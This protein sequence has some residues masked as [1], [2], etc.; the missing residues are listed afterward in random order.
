MTN[1]IIEAFQ[2]LGHLS[3]TSGAVL[4]LFFGLA[5]LIVFP[6]TI[7][8]VAAGASFGIGAAPIILVAGT[9]GGTLAFLL[10]RYIASG[11][12]RRKLEQRSKLEA[13]AEAVDKE[14][15][16]IVALMRL[17]APVSS[18]LQN[19]LFGLTRIHLMSFILA[20]LVFSAPQ[21]FLFTF[22]SATGRASLLEDK[23]FELTVVPILVTVVII[24]LISWRV[25]KLLRLRGR[26]DDP[27]KGC[28]SIR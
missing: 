17:G 11:W 1:C 4:A 24:A 16:R 27:N 28:H 21:V 12:F 6:R 23:P 26:S 22:L 10:A 19:Y 14:G 20:T 15:W 3:V 18:A 8:I 25:Q 7:L 2:V 13:I 9:A 5:A